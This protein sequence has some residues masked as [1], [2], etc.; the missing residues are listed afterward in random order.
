MSRFNT[1]TEHHTTNHEGAKA[2]ELSPEYKLYSLVCNSLVNDQ[3]YREGAEGLKELETLTP[4]CRP[5]FVGNLAAYARNEMNL[6][7]I[8]IVLAVLACRY[9]GRKQGQ[10]YKDCKSTER[11]TIS[12]VI[13]RA[14]ELTEALAFYGSINTNQ[15]RKTK[16]A[17]TVPKLITKRPASLIRGI[18]DVF[19]S[20]RFNE[21]QLAKYNRKGKFSLK[22]ALFLSHPGKIQQKELLDKLANDKL[23]TPTTWEVEF[24]ELGKTLKDASP[25]TIRA[26][27]LNLWTGLV[28]NKKLGHMALL[29]N[30][31]NILDLNPSNAHIELFCNQLIKGAPK[32]K[33]FPFRYYSAYTAIKD[34]LGNPFISQQIMT[35]LNICLKESVKCYPNFTGNTLVFTD[36]SGSMDKPISDKSTLTLSELGLVLGITLAGG[37]ENTVAGVFAEEIGLIDKTGNT[38]ADIQRG[39][40]SR[41]KVGHGTNGWKIL[42]WMLKQNF[43]VDNLC[44]FTD[45]QMYNDTT[46]RF[47][48]TVQGIDVLWKKYKSQ[49]PT[50]KMYLFDLAG[51][52]TSPIRIQDGAYLIS[53]WSDRIFEAVNR[54]NDGESA[55][56]MI[57]DYREENQHGTAEENDG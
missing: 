47:H 13:K 10:N 34:K 21:Y 25:E 41:G 32:G 27:K 55:V 49:Y 29:R 15:G 11:T 23:E 33:Q 18:K 8:P 5:A 53:G 7:T 46:N 54:M 35:A 1:P 6:R 28:S 48:Q 43:Q 36:T 4:L 17:H 57:M 45:M 16:G 26:A 3:Y 22:D 52:G 51:Y 24:S 37:L 2:F 50:C 30:L 56:Q 39:L 19:E 20:G 44:I 12:R 40:D 42:D 14:D 31:R 38:L 9:A